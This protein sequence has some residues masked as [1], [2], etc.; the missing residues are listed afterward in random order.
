MLS[1]GHGNIHESSSAMLTDIE[2]QMSTLWLS[3]QLGFFFFHI[4]I[5]SKIF[6]FGPLLIL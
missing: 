6:I 3:L 1:C 4:F 2:D 5:Q